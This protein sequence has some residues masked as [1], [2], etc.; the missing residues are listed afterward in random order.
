MPATLAAVKTRYTYT[1]RS[2]RYR[3]NRTGRFVPTAKVK[4][5]IDRVVKTAQ[6]EM[7]SLARQ[8]ADR[9]ITLGNWQSQFAERLKTL[10]VAS[11]MAGRG[12]LA[13]MT[14]A[15]YG[16]VGARLRFEY[17]RL[18]LFARDLAARKFTWGELRN[19]VEMYCAAGHV[20]HE[21]ARFGA[22]R[23]ANMLYE[24]NKLG[25]REKHCKTD[26]RGGRVGCI[27]LTEMGRVPI[28]TLPRPG[29]RRCLSRC[30]CTIGYSRKP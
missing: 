21:A 8:L 12:G 19:R 5:S 16:R 17:G 7:R 22:A 20:S 26:P 15:D 18:E 29:E 23:V 4:R 13:A 28:G 25:R 1:E 2:M 24:F 9:E 14:A 30:G 11:A 6:A 10:H 27:D 3:D